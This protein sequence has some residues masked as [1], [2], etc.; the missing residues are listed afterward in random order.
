MLIISHCFIWSFTLWICIIN[1]FKTYWSSPK[2]TDLVFSKSFI[3]SLGLKVFKTCCKITSMKFLFMTMTMEKTESR[4]REM[5]SHIAYGE[6]QCILICALG[7][8][9]PESYSLVL[10]GHFKD[11][12]NNN[13]TCLL[14][15]NIWRRRRR[16]IKLKQRTKSNN[17]NNN[18]N[19]SIIIIIICDI[20]NTPPQ[21][22]KQK[23]WYYVKKERKKKERKKE[24]ATKP[25]YQ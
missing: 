3:S 10:T 24:E 22:N 9:L 17:N 6:V 19:N 18:N 2:R 14:W 5:E 1:L 13:I 11:F 8:N 21:T 25:Q 20:Y 15:Y 23:Q 4:E 16:R 7:L 12:K